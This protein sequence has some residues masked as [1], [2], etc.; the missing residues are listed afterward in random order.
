LKKWVD[1][2]LQNKSLILFD[3]AY[4]AFIQDKDIPHSIYEIEGAKDCAIE[5]R[6]FSKNAGFTGVRCAYTVIPK[7]LIGYSS[8]NDEIELWPLWNRRQSTKFNGVSYVVQKGAEAVYSLEG[9]KQVRGLID[10]YMENAEIMKNKLQNAGYKVYG[11]DNAPYIWIK[12]PDQMT[13]WDFL[14]SFCK[15]SV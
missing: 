9:K 15:K 8:T 2:A 13:S 12:V 10:F 1:Y 5:F 7:N 3:A 6:S 4:E 14:I 11:G